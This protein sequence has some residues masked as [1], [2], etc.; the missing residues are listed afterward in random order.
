M[1]EKRAS[2]SERQRTEQQN[3]AGREWP[4]GVDVR[5]ADSRFRTDID[6]LDSHHSFSFGPHRA[7][8]NTHHGLLLVSNDDTVA[9]GSGFQTHPH[10]DMEIVTWVLEGE[11]EHKDSVGHTDIIYPGLAQRMSAGR[12][13]LHSEINPANEN[14]VR[15]VQMWVLPDQAEID[16]GYEQQDVRQE[17]DRGGLI[18]IAS[19]AG[20]D[21]AIR[22]QQ[23][24]ATLW[25][26]RLPARST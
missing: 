21:S 12:G 9:P 25:A 5:R 2:M 13:I 15:F 10:R 20:H 22:I 11:L 6:W 16:P 23:K 14:P 17:L 18:P 8:D 7:A 1:V 26:A 24:D 19:G 3:E 4:Q